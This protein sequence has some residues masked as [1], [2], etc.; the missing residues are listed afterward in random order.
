MG[1]PEWC[2]ENYQNFTS[3]RLTRT[4][5]KHIK[6]TISELEIEFNFVSRFTVYSIPCPYSNDSF[7]DLIDNNFFIIQYLACCYF[8]CRHQSHQEST[9]II[10]NPWSIN[11][12]QFTIHVQYVFWDHKSLPYNRTVKHHNDYE[13]CYCP[14]L[15]HS[16]G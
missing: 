8:T 12:K 9:K 7:I 3:R 15:T 4:H 10:K 13:A 14:V 1:G 6:W 2:F 16:F 5:L 11:E